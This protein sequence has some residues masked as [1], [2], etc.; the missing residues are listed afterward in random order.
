MPKGKWMGC[1]DVPGPRLLDL[2]RLID[3]AAEYI[4]SEDE[5]GE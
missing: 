4:H 3:D 5:E 1:F 2:K